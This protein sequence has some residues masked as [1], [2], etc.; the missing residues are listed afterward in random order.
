MQSEETL[1]CHINLRN[2]AHKVYLRSGNEQAHH[3]LKV[4]CANLQKVKRQAK[5]KWQKFFAIKCQ[6]NHFIDDPK[7]A[8]EVVFQIIEGFNAHHKDYK[9]KN[10]ANNN[11]KTSSNDKDNAMILKSFFHDV[12]NRK[13]TIDPSIL[14]E[15]TQRPA[16]TSL[17]M[18]PSIDEIKAAV[19]KM[20]NNKA[21]GISGTTTDMIKNLPE[22]GF[23]ILTSHINQFW[24]DPDYDHEAWHKTKL[25]L[26]YKGKGKQEDPNNWRGICLKETSA[27]ILSSLQR[28]FY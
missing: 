21:P 3:H 12:F 7:A 10:F 2:K 18:A 26:L 25:I 11:G 28:G 15:L 6:R 5:R 13:A 4:C 16:F 22:E 1:L 8:W 23:Q 24:E 17:D 20:K 9:P 19:K 27:K 14:D